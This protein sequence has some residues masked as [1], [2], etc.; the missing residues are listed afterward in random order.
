M[1]Q[2]NSQLLAVHPDTLEELHDIPLPEPSS[3]PHVITMFEGRI[4]I[5]LG[6]NESGPRAFWDPATR[7]LSLEA[8][9]G[10]P[11]WPE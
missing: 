3:V 9:W 8:A 2:P 10:P 7:K 5:Q 6:M 4:A 11:E 1:K